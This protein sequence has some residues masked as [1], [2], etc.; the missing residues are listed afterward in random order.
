MRPHYGVH[1]LEHRVP[2]VAASL[3]LLRLAYELF[4]AKLIAVFLA[5]GELHLG[6]H[7][8]VEVL[9]DKKAG[10]VGRELTLPLPLEQRELEGQNCRRRQEG[11]IAEP[12]VEQ[13]IGDR[14]VRRVPA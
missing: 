5:A 9:G 14:T 7:R 1:D 12:E 10:A 6:A 2:R 4:D 11:K 8:D 13:D 3:V